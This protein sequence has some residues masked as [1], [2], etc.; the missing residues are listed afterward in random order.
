MDS[1]VSKPVSFVSCLVS[2]IT[3]LKSFSNKVI[4]LS[5][6]SLT[7][8]SNKLFL[9]ATRFC[10]GNFAPDHLHNLSLLLVFAFACNVP[11][12]LEHYIVC[13][14]VVPF[15]FIAL[16]VN[17]A[18]MSVCQRFNVVR[19]VFCHPHVSLLAKPLFTT[20]KLVRPVIVYNV[21]SVDSAHHTRRV[22]PSMHCATSIHLHFSCRR[23]G[24]VTRFPM[25]SLN[26]VIFHL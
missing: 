9:S 1:T 7:K 19:S 18:P 14:S 25:L 17:F 21:R 4:A 15:Q 5:F 16:N 11:T 8:V 20:V 13:K 3:V 24:N 26:L 10:P 22:F 12:K 6:K 23:R 2:C